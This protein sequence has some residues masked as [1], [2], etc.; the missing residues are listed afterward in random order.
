MNIT[1]NEIITATQDQLR[2]WVAEYI[3]GW[4]W[5]RAINKDYFAKEEFSSW[6]IVAEKINGAVTMRDSSALLPKYHENIADAWLVIDAMK[7]CNNEDVQ[8]TFFHYLGSMR[9]LFLMTA[10]EAANSIC[11]AALLAKFRQGKGLPDEL[12]THYYRK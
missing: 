11:R 8:E 3:D 1:E 12:R 6:E 10:S 9:S 4:K 5:H 2:L 7:K